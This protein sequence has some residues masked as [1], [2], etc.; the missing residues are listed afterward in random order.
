VTWT[1]WST[2][3]ISRI[4]TLQERTGIGTGRLYQLRLLFAIGFE[5]RS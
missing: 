1:E 4:V 2:P 5:A 3:S